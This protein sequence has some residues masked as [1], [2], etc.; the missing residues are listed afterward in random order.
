MTFVPTI[1]IVGGVQSPDV[2]GLVGTF[3]PVIPVM[4]VNDPP[5]LYANG[6]SYPGVKAVETMPYM[7]LPTEQDTVTCV[8]VLKAPKEVIGN[9]TPGLATTSS[10]FD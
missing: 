3:N 6:W 9:P 2:L 5:T 8:G 10:E 1:S 7:T 4:V